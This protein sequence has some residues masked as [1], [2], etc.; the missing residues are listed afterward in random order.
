VLADD[1]DATRR[2]VHARWCAK[3]PAKFGM[4]VLWHG[5]NRHYRNP[6]ELLL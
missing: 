6:M 5:L 1:V 2:A 4:D 3:N